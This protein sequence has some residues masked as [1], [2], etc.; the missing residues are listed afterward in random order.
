MD[1]LLPEKQK[2]WK[3]LHWYFSE[4]AIPP[5]LTIHG[6]RIKRNHLKYI[7]ENIYPPLE[8]KIEKIILKNGLH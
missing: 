1:A 6:R 3:M 5:N 8:K 7:R 2:L 4:K